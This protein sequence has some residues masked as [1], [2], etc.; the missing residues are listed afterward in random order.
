MCYIIRTIYVIYAV[1]NCIMDVLFN[2][3]CLFIIIVSDAFDVA[4]VCFLH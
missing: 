4:L 3:V 2:P 1:I